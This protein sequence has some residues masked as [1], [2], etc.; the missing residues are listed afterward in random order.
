MSTALLS[1][2]FSPPLLSSR[3]ATPSKTLS[4]TVN[5]NSLF[6]LSHQ[7]RHLR[8]DISVAFG[9]EGDGTDF[10]GADYFD[11]EV[12]DADNEID[13]EIEYDKVL[14]DE[15]KEG[16]MDDAMLAP[17]SSGGFVSTVGWEAETLVDYRINEEEFHKIRLWD[18]DFFIRKEPDPDDDVYDFREVV[19][20]IVLFM[21]CF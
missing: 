18:C 9:D 15:T 17:L 1:L 14:I 2:R 3:L 8:R 11:E 5:L 21:Q 6:S 12:E 16:T 4:L 7:R 19:L 20:M 10:P 13:Y